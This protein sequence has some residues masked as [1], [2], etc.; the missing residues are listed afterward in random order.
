MAVRSSWLRHAV[1]ARSAAANQSEGVWSHESQR[2][3]RVM[4]GL[5]ASFP[6]FIA[7][8]SKQDSTVY[9]RKIVWSL[10]LKLPPGWD[11]M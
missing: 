9:K 1:R 2:A 7:I 5:D 6:M 11:A 3:H 10:S 4:L 8:V